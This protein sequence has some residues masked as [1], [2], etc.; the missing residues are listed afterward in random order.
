VAG[1]VFAFFAHIDEDKR[2][3][4]L[5]ASADIGHGTFPDAAFGIRNQL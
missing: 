1:R 4:G 2:R 3:L 5:L